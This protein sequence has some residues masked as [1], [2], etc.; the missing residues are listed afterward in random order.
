MTGWSVRTTNGRPMKISATVMPS[1]VNATLIPYCSSGGS[2]PSVRRVERRQRDAGDSRRQRERQI[3]QRIDDALARKL[4]A[5]EHP[6][7]DESKDGI[8]RRGRKRRADAEPIRG[9]DARIADRLPDRR[10]S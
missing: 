10:P 7:D 1:G 5:R 3:D 2:Q 9:H 8:D 4:V 6:R